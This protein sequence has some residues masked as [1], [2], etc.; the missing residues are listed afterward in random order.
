MPPGA[1]RKPFSART[2]IQPPWHSHFPPHCQACLLDLL[3]DMSTQ[4]RVS[5][6]KW[7]QLLGK[8]RNMALA[9]AVVFYH[10]SLL[11]NALVQQLGSRLRI[12]KILH[13]ALQ[14]WKQQ[15]LQLTMPIVIHSVVPRAPYLITGAT[16]LFTAWG[17]GSGYCLY[18]THYTYG[19]APSLCPCRTKWYP[20]IIHLARSITAS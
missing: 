19:T 2:S 10:F 17:V 7:Q 20:R 15:V 1:C 12:S 5:R 8:L 4:Q 6:I 3:L 9:I 14:D 11:Q 18:L 16:L 13:Q